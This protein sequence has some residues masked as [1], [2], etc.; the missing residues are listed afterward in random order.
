MNGEIVVRL[1]RSLEHD[2]LREAA[3][4]RPVPSV[5][6]TWIPREGMWIQLKESENESAA[7]VLK[8]RIFQIEALHREHGEMVFY[9]RNNFGTTM[10][11]KAAA[12]Q[13]V[14]LTY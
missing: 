6:R 8:D 1:E 3:A 2:K 12:F 11:V 10:V 4:D 5:E 9:A 7:D 14:V 13:P